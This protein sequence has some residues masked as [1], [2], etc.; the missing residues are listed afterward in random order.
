LN[1]S[2]F[3]FKYIDT[4]A[5][6]RPPYNPADLL[7]LYIYGYLNNIRSSRKLEKKTHR[8]VEVVWL[9]QKL[10]PDFKTTADFRKDNRKALKK[11]CRKF[12]LLCKKLD[13]FGAELIAIDGSKLRAVNNKQRNYTSKKLKTLIKR[14]DEKIEEYFKDCEEYDEEESSVK[15]VDKEELNEKIKQMQE[16]K[17]KYKSLLNELE[18]SGDSQISLTDP[19]SRRMQTSQG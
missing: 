9:L 11:V 14:I 5:T 16:R 17:D 8:N 18:E 3:S 1:L 2:E 7:K 19:E 13:L 10:R 4:K 6:G 12:T 15:K